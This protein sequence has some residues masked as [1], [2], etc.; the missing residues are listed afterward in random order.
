MTVADALAVARVNITSW[1]ESYAHVVAPEVLA[2][3]DVERSAV[4]FAAMLDGSVASPPTAAVVAERDGPDGPEVVGFAVARPSRDEPAVREVELWAIYVLA[5]AHGTG[6]AQQ[7][8]GAALDGA[9]ASL[10]VWQDPCAHFYARN[11]FIP[12]GAWR[13]HE[14]WGPARIVRLVR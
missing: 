12:D 11:G 5:A 14:P 6:A 1:R 7:L 13:V 9:P 10:W 8:L 3:M 4:G 2:A